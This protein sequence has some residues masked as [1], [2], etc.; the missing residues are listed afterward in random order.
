MADEVRY[1]R[2]GAAAWLTI[3]REARRN[4]LDLA[5]I[6]LL[7]AHLDR[8]EA[9]P[10][11]R[12]VCVTGAGTQAFCAGADLA[13][14]RAGGDPLAGP[15]RYAR[16][17]QRMRALEK[18]LVARVN[19][20]CLAGGL[21]PMLACDLV[22]ARE[23]ARLGLPEVTVGLFPMMVSALLVRDGIRKKV[24]ELVYTGAQIT[25]REAEALGLV[26]R[27]VPDGELD[28][29]VERALDGIAAAAPRAVQLGRRALAEA[30]ALPPD[31]AI[32]LLCRR[33]GDVLA[34]EDA[35]EGLAAFV[36]KR[37]PTW[38]GR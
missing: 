16:L 4:A 3:D 29:A 10:S 24:L 33:L 11:V 13:A 25:A 6:E 30:E 34:T 14:A 31:E 9:D 15:R 35:V 18:P 7:L 8:A 2:R 26:T 21:G 36:E 17:L 23:G 12:V 37:K 1:E 28:A 22:Y 5:T 38:K 32:E 20:H 19:G 27:A